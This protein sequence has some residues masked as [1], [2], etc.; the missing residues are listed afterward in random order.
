MLLTCAVFSTKVGSTVD[1]VWSV[2]SAASNGKLSAAIL[3]L[4]QSV[5]M[6]EILLY[7]VDCLISYVLN[8]LVIYCMD[9]ELSG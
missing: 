1:I 3:I 4:D 2:L 8:L 6:P 5:N 9:L 7:N